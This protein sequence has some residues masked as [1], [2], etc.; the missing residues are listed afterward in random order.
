MADVKQPESQPISGSGSQAGQ[1]PN[2]TMFGMSHS[3]TALDP[4]YIL[5][6]S[7]LGS[8]ANLYEVSFSGFPVGIPDIEKEFVERELGLLCSD[9]SLPATSFGTLEVNGHYQGRT[10][11]FAHTRIYPSLS[12]SF[13]ET[14]DHKTLM[15]FE[16]WQRFVT[17][18]GSAEASFNHFY[19]MRFPSEY[20]CDSIFITKFEKN[21]RGSGYS[22]TLVY[23]FIR[24]FPRNVTSVP[25]SYGQSEFTKVTVEFAYDRYIVNPH[26][27]KAEVKLG[28]SPETV[29]KNLPRE[30]LA[31]HALTNREM[32]ESA[33]TPAQKRILIDADSNYPIGS[34]QREALRQAALAGTYTAP[35]AQGNIVRQSGRKVPASAIDKINKGF[36]T[37]PS[38]T[39]LKPL[40]QTSS[41]AKVPADSIEKVSIEDNI[42]ENVNILPTVNAVPPPD[43]KRPKRTGNN[44]FSLGRGS[45]FEF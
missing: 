19:R 9:A 23:Q 6:E 38:E 21:Y 20:K 44:S 29:S 22:D 36:D 7:I 10:E 17:E 13:Y 37:G 14:R 4:R 30:D 5:S 40:S 32:I 11:V 28:V 15:F 2:P 43:N 1:A 41:Q 33:G 18:E 45:S 39:R 25:V 31:I 27:K 34:S 24:A 35:D 16:E 3:K 12:L 42:K 8:I 26:K